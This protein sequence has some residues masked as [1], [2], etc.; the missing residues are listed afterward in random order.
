MAAGSN[1][2]KQIGY[3]K[4]EFPEIDLA[5]KNDPKKIRIIHHLTARARKISKKTIGKIFPRKKLSDEWHIE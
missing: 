3:S 1:A 5:I 2:Y 4:K